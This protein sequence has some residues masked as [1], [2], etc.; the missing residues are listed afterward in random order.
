V[1]YH[2]RIDELL[3][4]ATPTPFWRILD[5]A[6]YYG[7][8]VRDHPL[9]VGLV[10]AAAAIGLLRLVAR[11]PPVRETLSRHWLLVVVILAILS[12]H[13]LPARS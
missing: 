8:V 11:R 6:G 2:L 12:T 7:K 9:L 1:G 10:F 4:T 3:Q 13:L 5:L